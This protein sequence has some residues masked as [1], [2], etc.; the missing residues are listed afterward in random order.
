[1][2]SVARPTRTKSGM[3]RIVHKNHSSQNARPRVAASTDSGSAVVATV[4]R[5][6]SRPKPSKATAEFA[7]AQRH[8]GS[9]RLCAHEDAV[10]GGILRGRRRGS[11]GGVDGSGQ[12]G[13]RRADERGT[14]R[15]VGALYGVERFGVATLREATGLWSLGERATH[16]HRRRH[17]G[18]GG[19]FVYGHG[20]VC[21][22]SAS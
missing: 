19:V 3:A 1:M 8:R 4:G 13:G 18:G 22:A 16:S 17:S 2:V 10:A 5:S 15:G 6:G 11:R 7:Y 21:G 12:L 9:K 20:A 14:G